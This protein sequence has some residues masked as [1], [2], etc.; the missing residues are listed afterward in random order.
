MAKL[1]AEYFP[2]WKPHY[3]TEE[4]FYFSNQ[5]AYKA[6]RSSSSS[7]IKNPIVRKMV[8]EKCGNKCVSCGNRDDLQI[9]H[10]ISVYSAY[11]NKSLVGQLN[12]YQN[13]QV[14]CKAC[15]TSKPPE[16]I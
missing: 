2:L 6:L 5:V 7:F 10:I 11:L 9:D 8:M 3:R 12:T 13:L 14:L 16:V 4:K 1:R 15:N